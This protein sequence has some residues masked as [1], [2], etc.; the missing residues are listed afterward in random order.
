MAARVCVCE[1]T[2]GD[3]A[4]RGSWCVR[5]LGTLL[6]AVGE[7]LESAGS[8]RWRAGSQAVRLDT[9][10]SPLWARGG[11]GPAP[12]S[13]SPVLHAHGLRLEA[14]RARATA[15]SE[16]TGHLTPRT[17]R[18]RP[19][20]PSGGSRG[21]LC[22]G[23]EPGSV[24]GTEQASPPG[25]RSARL[26]TGAASATRSRRRIVRLTA[27]GRLSRGGRVGSTGAGSLA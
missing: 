1:A 7:A 18:R 11:R 17:G 3:P 8:F 12:A 13:T 24:P 15:R 14:R 25:T 4:S 19:V 26:M 9:S 5:A 27:R 20:W 16:Q 6:F 22:L 21:H 23:P 2:R 10:P